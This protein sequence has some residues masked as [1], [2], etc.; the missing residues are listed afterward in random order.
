MGSNMERPL[1]PNAAKTW[2]AELGRPRLKSGHIQLLSVLGTLGPKLGPEKWGPTVVLGVEYPCHG[3]TL[4]FFQEREVARSS[5]S[6]T[7]ERVDIK[8]AKP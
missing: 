3:E 5:Q 8:P 4:R 2:A 6:I 1:T 7:V